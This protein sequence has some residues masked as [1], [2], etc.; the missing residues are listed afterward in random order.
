MKPLDPRPSST[1][2]SAGVLTLVRNW[3]R[4]IILLNTR[5]PDER[6]DLLDPPAWLRTVLLISLVIDLFALTRVTAS[7]IPSVAALT[8]IY[9]LS[10]LVPPVASPHGLIRTPRV[11]FLV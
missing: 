8:I 9:I 1:L 4:T 5:P 6:Q 11:A 7:A 3:M 2:A 10:M